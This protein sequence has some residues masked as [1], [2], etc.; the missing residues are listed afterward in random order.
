MIDTVLKNLI[1][2]RIGES[3]YHRFLY[4][5]DDRNL[6]LY[7]N[8]P[9]RFAEGVK[10]DL[11]PSDRMHGMIAFLGYHERRMSNT[12]SALARKK[13]GLLVDVGANIGYFS[14]VWVSQNPEQNR[15]IALEPS[16]RVLPLLKKNV[17][18]NGFDEQIDVLDMAAGLKEQ[19]V[20]FDLGPKDEVGWGGL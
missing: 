6:N 5:P 15:A 13:G 18:R 11:V 19:C 1:P 16:P 20:R 7:R 8:A 4:P 12:V 3:I 2:D 14:L 9:L 17:K 10:V